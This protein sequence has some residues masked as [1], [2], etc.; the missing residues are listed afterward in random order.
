M[1]VSDGTEIMVVKEQG[2]VVERVRRPHAR[3]ARRSPRH[4]PHSL[5][6]HRCEQWRNAQPVYR[7][8]GDTAATRP[9]RARPQRQPRQ[10]R[11]ARRR[12]RHVAGHRRR[13]TATSSP[14]CSP[15]SITRRRDQHSDDRALERALLEV[16]PLLEGAFSFVLADEGHVIGVRDPHGFRPLCL[17]KLDNGWVLASETPGARHRRRPLRARARPGRD[18]GDRRHRLPLVAPVRGVRCRRRRSA[19]SSSSTS[20]D[21]TASSTGTTSTRPA[22]AW[23][24]SSPRRRRSMRD[25]VMGVPESGVPAAEG[26][27]RVSGIPYG[28]GL[29][30]NR[31]VG[32]TLHRTEPGDARARRCA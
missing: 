26:F 8:V 14:S 20:P 11:G 4:R 5:L 24:S 13:A 22:C 23:A 9:V 16:L 31:Y 19:C 1:A 2:L 12:S 30:K 25:M 21:P 3:A 32:R 27:A 28:Q 7:S 15:T 29:V 18:G 17:G 6:D 10:H